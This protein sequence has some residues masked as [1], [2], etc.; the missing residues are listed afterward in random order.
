MEKSIMLKVGQVSSMA[1]LSKPTADNPY[2]NSKY[3]PLN[4]VMN[5]LKEPLE[6]AGLAYTFTVTREETGY[7]TKMYVIDLE[8]GESQEMG[9][10]PIEDLSP[11]KVGS[12][13]SYARRYLLLSVFN[14]AA[15]QD[16]DGNAAQGLNGSPKGSK[17]TNTMPKVDFFA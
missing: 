11:Q 6:K 4:V 9:E 1:L 15:E 17:K 3:I 14:M 10:F 16:D 7:K 13:I 12:A 2:F 5:E 8:T